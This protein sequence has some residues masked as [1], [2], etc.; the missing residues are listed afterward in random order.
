[1]HGSNRYMLPS[2]P[3]TCDEVCKALS[4]FLDNIYV[5]FGT[6]GTILQ[7]KLLWVLTVIF[8]KSEV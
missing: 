7:Q 1:M 2:F 8:N 4:F 6:F 3:L 5:R